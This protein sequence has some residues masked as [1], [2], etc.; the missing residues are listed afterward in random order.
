M[1]ETTERISIKFNAD[2]LKRELGEF[3]FATYQPTINLAF[4]RAPVKLY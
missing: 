3:N 4:L 1:S 2:G